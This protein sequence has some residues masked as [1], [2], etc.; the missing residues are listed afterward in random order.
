MNYNLIPP[1]ILR[2]TGLIINETPKFQCKNPTAEDHSIYSKK[3]NLRIHLKLQETFSYFDTYTL[4]AQEIQDADEDDLI[5]FTL[6]QDLWD[7]YLD[8]WESTIK[9]RNSLYYDYTYKV[10]LS[11]FN[12][13]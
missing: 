5:W 6:D 1:F 4:T 8:T 3:H 13:N 12:M 11:S 2:E 9:I 7:P 10:K